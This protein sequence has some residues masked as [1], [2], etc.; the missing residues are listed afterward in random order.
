MTFL[1]R[2]R[3]ISWLTKAF[4]SK[5]GRIIVTGFLVGIIGFFLISRLFPY[6]P[7]PKRH[8]K[9]AKVGKCL[10]DNL[11]E[12]ILELLSLGLTM[13]AEDGSAAPGLAQ[14]WQISD[15]GLTYTFTLADNLFWQDE[16]PVKAEQIVYS[17]SDVDQETIDEK[18]IRFK[19]KEPFSPF[20]II[21][22]KPVLQENNLGV[23]P[24]QIKRIKK[25]GNLIEKITLTGP[26]KD[27]TFR[28]YPTEKDALLGFKLGEVDIL[29][30]FLANQL[31]EEWQRNTKVTTKISQ[32]Q[33]LALF[34]NTQDSFLADKST[35][36]ALAYSII[37]KTEGESRATG[38][39]NPQSWAYNSQVKLYEYNPTK[40]KELLEKGSQEKIKLATTEPFLTLAEEIKKSWKETLDIEAEIEV[41]N[42]LPEDYQVFLGIQEIPLD[43]DQYVLWHSTRAENIT[44]LKS[45]K[46]DKLL[47]DGRKITDLEERKEKYF[48]FQKFLAEESPAVFLSHP[49]IYRL[50]R[51]E[52]FT[53]F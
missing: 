24:Y 14:S 20:L 25:S 49:L 40:A 7:R 9:I 44:H 35:R 3:L 22:S 8:D 34:F 17:F 4:F 51:K 10:V 1:K 48:D 23:G 41:I 42:T 32:N 21:L 38:P 37:N 15:D 16:T 29:D 39:I 6:L 43:P 45:P 11:P 47:E 53:W 33:Y 12:E 5:H 46:I 36:Q 30:G 52:I 50:E 18:T 2:I 19:L 31:E 28:F 27:I 26:E 13:V